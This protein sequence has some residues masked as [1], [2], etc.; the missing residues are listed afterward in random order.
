MEASA[1]ACVAGSG[2][3][4]RACG[5]EPLVGSAASPPM[6]ASFVPTSTVA[7]SCTRIS[8]RTPLPGLGTSVSTLSVEISSRGSSAATCSPCCLS[9]LVTVPSETDTPIWGIT[10]STAVFVA[11]A[12]VLRELPERRDD[13]LDLR[14]ERLLERRRERDGRVRR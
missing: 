10:T 6:T 4:S 7:P 2:G 5:S 14:D 12:L 8:V 13:V 3:A 1:A 9:H 11:T